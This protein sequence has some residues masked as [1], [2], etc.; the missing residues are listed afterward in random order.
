MPK[1]AAVTEAHQAGLADQ[2]FEA[3]R[4]DRQIIDLR[5]RST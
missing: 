2:Q 1:N 5:R 4:E 3:E